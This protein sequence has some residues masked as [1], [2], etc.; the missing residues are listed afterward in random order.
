M[1]SWRCASM[2]VWA[3]LMAAMS[4]SFIGGKVMLTAGA[5]K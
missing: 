2:Y 1:S 4:V 5:G 3:S